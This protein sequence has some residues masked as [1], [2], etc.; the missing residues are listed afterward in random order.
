MSLKT[1]HLVFIIASILLAA[2]FGV[3]ELRLWS[4]THRA[5][6]LALG[7]LSCAL[8]V[9]LTAYSKYFLRKLRSVSFL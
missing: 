3:W 4:E 7:A 5:L 6:D 1:F 9:V 8:A 2:G